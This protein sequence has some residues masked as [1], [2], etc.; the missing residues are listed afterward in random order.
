GPGASDR[1]N[2]DKLLEQMK[3]VEVDRRSARFLCVIVYMKH[4]ADPRPLIAEGVWEGRILYEPRGANGF[5]YDPVF[6]VPDFE[7]S[8]AQLSPA[9]KNCIS[10]RAVALKKLAALLADTD[11]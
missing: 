5:G 7:C 3:G 9:Q 11:R 1:E 2:L 8:S 4:A 6:W 10:H